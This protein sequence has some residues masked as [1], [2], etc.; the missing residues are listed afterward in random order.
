[1][2]TVDA[3]QS[4]ITAL[5]NAEYKN[6]PEESSVF[7]VGEFRKTIDL[8][9]EWEIKIGDNETWHK[10]HIPSSLNY[11]EKLHFRKSFH[12]PS[13][14]VNYHSNLIALGINYSSAIKLNGTYIG[15][16]S[17]GNT[18]FS[19]DILDRI[20]KPGQDNLIEIEIDKLTNSEASDLLRPQP[21]SWKHYTGIVREIYIQLLPKISLTDWNMSYNFKNNLSDCETVFTFTF[22][23]FNQISDRNALGASTNIRQENIQ[24]FGYF[25]EIYNLDSGKL[26]KD[27]RANPKFINIHQTVQD[28]MLLE[29][30]DVELWSP[31]NPVLYQLRITLIRQN[32]IQIDNFRSQFGFREIKVD[33]N[34]FTLN[35]L[36]VMLKGVYRVEQH[37]DYGISIPWSKQLEDLR[38][39]KDLGLNIVRSGPYPNHPYFYELCDQLGIMVLEEIPVSQ[40]PGHFIAKQ[41][42]IDYSTAI[43]QE[44]INRDRHH[45]SIIGWGLGSNLDVSS[46]GTALY[47]TNLAET[48]REIDN[49]LLYY[50]SEIVE[51][52]ICVDITDFK[53]TDFYSPDIEFLKN[54]LTYIRNDLPDKPL[55]IG[56][57]GSVVNPG[58]GGE[59]YL[60]PNSLEHQ[61]KYVSDLYNLANE[62]EDIHGI[63]FWSFADWEGDIPLLSSGPTPDNTLYRRGLLTEN[64]E[65]RLAYQNL[66]A[67]ILNNNY[68]TL[69]SGN[70]FENSQENFIYVGFLI[71]I[72]LIGAL[73]QHRWFGQNFRRSLLFPKIFF[74]DI[75]E[76][77]NMQNWQ[78]NLLSL[79]ISSGLALG[80]ASLCFYYKQNIY[81]DL[82][83]TQFFLPVMLKN[84]VIYLIWHPLLNIIFITLLIF[85][86]IV[87]I[88]VI[89][90]L[91]FLFLGAGG[92][93][94]KSFNVIVWS[95]SNLVFVLLFMI[96]FY[97]ALQNSATLPV[98][99]VIA[100]IFLLWY[101][102]RFILALKVTYQT[103]F[104]LSLIS[105]IAIIIVLT[106]G[107]NYFFQYKYQSFTY[108]KMYL[109]SINSQ[110]K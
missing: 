16:H 96:P 58:I 28:T 54:L 19:I 5:I 68:S 63:I 32:N 71:I 4:N 50:S 43:L 51:K 82:I 102:N 37:P 52:D 34:G 33:N 38:L 31:E 10:I 66:R 29:F 81:F 6:V 53:L 72:I 17:A 93:L 101:I 84:I 3:G 60:N 7:S 55:F 108:T 27:N 100:V 83:I 73:K 78:T 25:V 48:A 40:I 85:L 45:P 24:E 105:Y 41:K 104:K 49:R 70:P 62:E 64:R 11:K 76:K 89:H 59:G 46:A 9:G 35:G 98:Y 47:L 67:T 110:L 36:P 103:N 20:L 12:I 80:I 22:Q 74:E 107:F 99:A 39:I 8:N 86:S 13:D 21:W 14:A 90:N 91:I 15:S 95:G 18:S 61:A 69:S 2:I 26:V 87:F 56:R 88:A 23:N 65:H 75:L 30:K 106:G 57:I 97:S 44:M 42:N 77:R 92:G 1:M 79:V 94:T 109:N